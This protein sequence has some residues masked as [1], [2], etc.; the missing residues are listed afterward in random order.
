MFRTRNRKWIR[1]F[2]L[3]ELLV[4]I[5]IIAVLVALLLPAVQQA[6][7]AARRSQCKN[8]L[9]QYGLAMH[10][11]HEAH[12]MFAI[13]GTNWGWPGLSFHARLLPFMD[14]GPLYNMINQRYGGN[15]DWDTRLSDN[16]TL[17][18]H[19]VPYSLCPS[20]NRIGAN[21]QWN[22]DW[23]A[24]NPNGGPV[25][26][27]YCGSLGS[28]SAPS[29][30]GSC[31][32]FQIFI[33]TPGSFPDHGNTVDPSQVSGMGTRLG[34]AVRIGDVIDGTSNTIHIG[35]MLPS[36][37]DHGNNGA[38]FWN[39]NNCGNWH[40][41]TLVP[42]NNFNTCP[43]AT[44]VQITNSACTNSNNWNWSWGFRS[45][46]SGG[47]Q[48]VFADGSVHFLAASIN[49]GTYQALGGKAD[50]KSVGDF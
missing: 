26:A 49:A 8:N 21:P 33:Q 40:A 42:I 23:G 11:Y 5:A 9:K 14:Q 50:N 46:H 31:N 15:A 3:I 12:G 6:R 22:G 35:E 16:F 19:K 41:H 47:A 13:G 48:F 34:A 7:E 4:V 24:P 36:C 27:N 43:W 39:Y 28:Q 1:A 2:T 20:D 17:H 29:A 18:N 32:Q 37:N 45:Q 38:S 44:P 30:S 10:N 25:A